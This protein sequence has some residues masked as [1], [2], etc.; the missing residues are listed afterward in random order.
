MSKELR[1]VPPNWSHPLE[2]NTNRHC[3]EFIPMNNISYEEQKAKNAQDPDGGYLGRPEEYVPYK[4]EECS[5]YQL[6]ETVTEGCPLTPPFAT[7]EELVTFLSTKKDY[8]G[9]GPMSKAAA[10]KLVDE[11]WQPTLS[12]EIK[13]SR[14]VSVK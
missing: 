4:K 1:M 10:Q 5:W 12:L 7:K 8:W 3:I 6:F 14:I 2:Y 13:D 9:K 11:E